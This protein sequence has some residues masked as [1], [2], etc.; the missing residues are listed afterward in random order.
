MI[1]YGWAD[2]ARKPIITIIEKEGNV[3]EH[4]F[5]RELSGFIVKDLDLG[6]SV[7]R[8]ILT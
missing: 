2:S 3:H 7:V 1:E 6:L 4:S 8:A 5:I